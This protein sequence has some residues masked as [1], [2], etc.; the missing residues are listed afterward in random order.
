[1]EILTGRFETL[2]QNAESKGLRA[3]MKKAD[4]IVSERDSLSWQT[5]D[6]YPS[7]VWFKGFENN[8]RICK[9]CG[10]IGDNLGVVQHDKYR[11]CTG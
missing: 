9:K 3:N 2:R 4:I 7:S 8:H 11:V 6:K 1:M 10:G 5:S